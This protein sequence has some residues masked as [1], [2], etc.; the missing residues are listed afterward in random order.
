MKIETTRSNKEFKVLDKNRLILKGRRPKWY[1]SEVRFFYNS[2]TYEIKKKGFWSTSFTILESGHPI[3]AIHW[4][5]KKSYK[6]ILK[7]NTSSLQYW[8][9]TEKA[10]KWYA[11]DRS[12][13]LCENSE[14]PILTIHYALKKWKESMEAE[15]IDKDTTN[16]VLLICALFVM[17]IQQS[18]ENAAASGGFA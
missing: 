9:K 4:S 14:T 10:G 2:K 3:G 8:L 18:A 16:Y 5:L 13:T 11:A 1:S 12:Y 15:F 7:N 17:R 6:I